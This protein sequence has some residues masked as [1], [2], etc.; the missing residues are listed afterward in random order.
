LIARKERILYRECGSSSLKSLTLRLLKDYGLLGV[1]AIGS[2]LKVPVSFA[3]GDSFDLRMDNLQVEAAPLAGQHRAFTP[4]RLD[5]DGRY[6]VYFKEETGTSHFIGSAKSL[7]DAQY[8]YDMVHVH[9]TGTQDGTFRSK[10]V[11]DSRS[12]HPADMEQAI[13]A[14]VNDRVV[15]SESEYSLVELTD[16]LNRRRI[17]NR[18]ANTFTELPDGELSVLVGDMHIITDAVCFHTWC[19]CGGGTLQANE[20]GSVYGRM[21]LPAYPSSSGVFSFS[22]WVVGDSAMTKRVVR[23][24]NTA[25][26]DYRRSAFSI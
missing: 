23:L 6:R 10:G 5:K 18:C 7:K 9:M 25:K 13:H 15:S 24:P 22:K 3:N 12:L 11:Q 20:N 2:K 1:D 19:S 26:N 17:K 21:R 8:I 4:L 14:L 16:G